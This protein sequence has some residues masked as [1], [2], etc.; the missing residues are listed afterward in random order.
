M[1][2]MHPDTRET[3]A[4]VP[5]P[6]TS[7]YIFN[8][9]VDARFRRQGIARRLLSA[10]HS[11]CWAAGKSEAYLHYRKGDATAAG[12]YTAMGYQQS[13][14]D[15]AWIWGPPPRVLMCKQLEA[16]SDAL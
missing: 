12:M 13:A 1:L 4:S 6:D 5:P 14:E 11:V 3:G 2:S 9:A 15:V 10:C 7:P 16:P 8:L